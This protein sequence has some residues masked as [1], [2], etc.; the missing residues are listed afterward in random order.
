M[1][2]GNGC[3][4]CTEKQEEF[5]NCADVEILE[6]GE[7][8]LKKEVEQMVNESIQKNL[9]TTKSNFTSDSN[10]SNSTYDVNSNN[11]FN[12]LSTTYTINST[13]ASKI[14]SISNN[15]EIKENN[16]NENE[17]EKILLIFDTL[18]KLFN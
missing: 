1:T 11:T 10:S 2:T 3:S 9:K 16:K 6:E 15:D 8:I 14:S 18:L 7:Y 12:N 4:G 13:A 5:Y 17:N